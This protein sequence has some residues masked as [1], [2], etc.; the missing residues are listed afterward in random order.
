[1]GALAPRALFALLVSATLGLAYPAKAAAAAAA[2]TASPCTTGEPVV[3]AGYTIK[4]APATP[5]QAALE[6]GYQPEPA[7][8]E[9]HVVGTY[10]FGVPQ[11]VESGFAFAQFKCQYYCNGGT[12]AAGSFFVKYAGEGSQIGSYCSCYSELL[13]PESFVADNQT[14]IGAWNSI[15]DVTHP[16]GK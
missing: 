2:S 12:P 9:N 16:G 1:M 5:T 6:H 14:L 8:A 13:D 3:T 15:C 11:P 10:T 7:W 4:Y